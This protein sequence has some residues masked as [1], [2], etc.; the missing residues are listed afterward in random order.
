[1]AKSADSAS[2]AEEQQQQQHMQD[3]QQHMQHDEKKSSQENMVDGHAQEGVRI[4]E[5]MAISWSR[6]SLI[7]VFVFM[8]LI[9]FT[10]AMRSSL[11]SNLMP[12][13]LSAFE[14]H[15]L[16]PVID[17]VASIC[18]A[19]VYMPL[20]KVLNM[21]DRTLGFSCMIALSTLGM[22]LMASCNSF[23]VYA[24]ANVFYS[25]GFAGVI[26]S[27]D[28]MTAD[29]SS[30]RSRGLAYAFT[31]SPFLITAFAGPKASETIY[32]ANWRWGFGAWA[33]VLPAVAVPMVVLMQVGKRKARKDGHLSSRPEEAVVSRGARGFMYYF[34]EFDVVGVLLLLAGFVLFLL[35]FTIAASSEDTWRSA[36]IIA[37]I[38]LGLILII[39]FALWER[40]GA[41]RPFVPWH[42]LRARNVL[43]SCGLAACYQISYYCWGSYFTSYL[44]VVYGISIS[45][46]GY[47]ASIFDVVNGVNLFVIGFLIRWTG[48]FKWILVCAVPL[49]VL[50]QGL[51][52]YFRQP[53]FDVGY[54]IMCQVYMALAGGA[55]ILVE[56]VSAMSVCRHDDVAAVLALLNLFGNIG[57]GL[58]NSISGAIWTNTLPGKL[59]QLL[60]AS[61]AADWSTI[62]DSLDV[63]LSYP[64]GSAE[65]NAI[66]ASYAA[67]QRLMLI[68]GTCVMILGTICVFAI[69]DINVKKVNQVKGMVL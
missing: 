16:I 30:M 67:T 22:V 68:T 45:N 15:S 44:Q 66:I 1:M 62:Y 26:F 2:A 27:V 23:Q 51:L 12:F 39:C 56:Q 4:A 52:I 36:H 35:P 11:A 50:G 13:V 20:A 29:I 63:Q 38:V 9:Y 64:M 37:M 47:I 34:D 31:S 55:M 6:G 69:K 28:V 10:N 32:E 3:R 7:A 43:G 46:A 33:I 40:F 19:S 41:K 25:I 49:Y 5:G 65:R 59:Q 17:V 48:R 21:W 60:P 61:V 24:A 58:G 14:S 42:L 57:S 8:W 18:S 53:T 54:T